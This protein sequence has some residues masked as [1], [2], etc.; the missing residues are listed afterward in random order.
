MQLYDD[1]EPELLLRARVHS[2]LKNPKL[3]EA[4][5]CGMLAV[6]SQCDEVDL[7]DLANGMDRKDGR[8]AEKYLERLIR[9]VAI[10]ARVSSDELD[11][12]CALVILGV[13]LDHHA[14][15]GLQD[16]AS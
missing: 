3:L 15:S 13:L 9:R 11:S 16:E 12:R 10:A 4:H 2:V 6:L 7:V 1:P 14:A 5:D 8:T